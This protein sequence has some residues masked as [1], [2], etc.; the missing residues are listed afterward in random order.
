MQHMDEATLTEVEEMEALFAW[1]VA[2]TLPA[3]EQARVESY[4]VQHPELKSHLALAREEH[5]ATVDANEAIRPLAGALEQ[6]RSER[7]AAPV[8]LLVWIERAL[9]RVGEF[10]ASVEPRRL[11]L[12]GVAACLLVLAQ[13]GLIGVL[14][15][16]RGGGTVYETA[17]GPAAS[18]TFAMVG[19]APDATASGIEKLLRDNGLIITGGPGVDGLYRVRLSTAKLN[20]DES[21]Q[22]L[23]RITA[24]SDI[25]SF[26]ALAK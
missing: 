12:A 4:L 14:M 7:A 8:S 9:D 16:G 6:F 3:P 18:G 25:V 19:F 10:V 13:T 15:T 5:D 21:A 24:R 1:Y 2:G 11:A 23:T 20:G 17:A 22:A 26:A